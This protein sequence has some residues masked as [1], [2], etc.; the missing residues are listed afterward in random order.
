[1]ENVMK[2]LYGGG[3]EAEVQKKAAEASDFVKRYEKGDPAEGYSTDEA[4]QHY[5]EV[6][7]AATPEQMQKA[8]KQAVERLTPAERE[9]FAKMLQQRQAGQVPQREGAEAAGGVG[10]DDLLGGLLGGGMSQSGG[11]GSGTGGITDILGGLLGGASGQPGATA[12]PGTT[13][14]GGGF[15]FG[16]ILSHPAAKAVLAGVAAYGMKEM[17]EGRR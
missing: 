3:D 6:A 13:Q 17:M 9:D 2:G 15:D 16:D 1:M 12:Q 11:A 14:G 7:A 4:I 8:T 10:L 5:R